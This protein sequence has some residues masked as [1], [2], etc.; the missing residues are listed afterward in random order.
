MTAL[1]AP[2]TLAVEK[3]EGVLVLTEANFDEELSKHEFLLVE[4]YAPWCGHCKKLTPEYAAAAAILGNQNP[5]LYLAKVDATENN[6]LAERFEVKGFPT[7]FWFNNGVKSEYT[8]GRTTDTIVTWVNKRAGPASQEVSCSDLSGKLGKLNLVYFG[9]FSG[10][11]FDAFQSVAKQNEKFAFFQASGECAVEHGTKPH[12]ISIFRNFDK[13]P[14]HYSGEHNSAAILSWTETSS[15]PT[16]IEFSEDFIEP[17][18]GKGRAALIL[19][20]NDRDVAFNQVFQDA[21]AQ[22]QGQILFV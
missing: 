9:D 13:S 1:F 22:L 3:D 2:A 18:F 19:F 12:S 16:V 14:L 5:P 20:S 10:E 17:I 21:A 15:I 6:A 11:L 4:F 8:G 7:L